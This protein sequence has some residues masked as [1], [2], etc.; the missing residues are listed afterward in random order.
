MKTGEEVSALLK[1][2]LAYAARGW[3]VFPVNAKKEPLTKHGHLDATTDPVQIRKWWKKH[4]DA[5]IGYVPGTDVVFIDVDVK[6]GARGLE[7]FA[8]LTRRLGPLPATVKTLTPSGGFQSPL[9]KPRD[10]RI[11]KSLAPGIDLKGDGKSYVILPPSPYDGSDLRYAWAPNCSPDEQAIATLPEPWID[12]IRRLSPK[13]RAKPLPDEILEGERNVRLTSLA[14]SIRQ[15]GGTE[16]EIL[17]TLRAVNANRCRPPLEDAEVRGI[18]SS[19]AKYESGDPE[20]EAKDSVTDMCIEIALRCEL[21]C[22]DRGDTYAAWEDKDGVRRVVRIGGKAGGRDFCRYISYEFFK[23]N[24]KG[25]ASH[26]INTAVSVADANAARDGARHPLDVRF[27]VNDGAVWLDLC[28]DRWRAIKVTAEGWEVVDRPPYLFRRFPHQLPLPVP[29]RGGDLGRLFDLLNLKSEDDW[30]LVLAWLATVPLVN[31]PRPALILHGVKGATKSSAARVLRQLIDP[32]ALGG[33]TLPRDTTEFAQALDH[34]AI[35]WFDNLGRLKPWQADIMC[36]AVT[37]GAF[38]KRELYTN[39]D[40]ILMSF[41]RTFILTGINVPTAAPDFLDRTILLELQPP[42]ERLEES[43]LWR[44]FDEA[45]PEILG[46][47]LDALAG[48][49]RLRESITV[50][51]LPRMADFARYGAA[52]AEALGIGAARFLEAY[53]RNRQTQ[54]AEVVEGDPLANALRD[55]A[56]EYRHWKGTA[57]QLLG[58]LDARNSSMS[59]T[60]E[61]PKSPAALGRWLRTLQTTLAEGGVHIEWPTSHKQGREITIRVDDDVPA[62]DGDVV[63]E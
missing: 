10:L 6:N 47:L 54:V 7:S 41:R 11:P 58:L 30:V 45:R 5:G 25:A 19:L 8:E 40:D 55:F 9:I 1:S 33:L 31:V 34:H 51:N 52:A 12:E 29:T 63:E 42:T 50:D 44:R 61:W 59:R 35:P 4:P 16:D 46:R 22:D 23:E 18:A 32:S 2:A 62:E 37:G 53:A 38:T 15:R 14:G 57:S 43:V 27:Q 28:D 26:V 3:R 39:T 21:F 56:A 60:R 20:P 24:G 17:E 36:R 13:E 48:A 49:L